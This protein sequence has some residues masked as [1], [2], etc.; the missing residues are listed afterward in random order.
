MSEIMVK[1]P[2][3]GESVTEATVS[4]WLVQPGSVVKKYEPLLEAMSDKV[5]TE[6]PASEDGIVQTLL[7]TEGDVVS[8]GSDI[9]TLET[10]SKK[11]EP[12]QTDSTPAVKPAET[13]TNNRL[14]FSPAVLKIAG[15][16][17]IDLNEVKGTGTGG[18]I[19]RKD[20]LS[21]QPSESIPQTVETVV[22]EKP[23]LDRPTTEINTDDIVTISPLRKA[24]AKNLVQSVTEIP[25]AWTMIEVDVTNLVKLRHN[26]KQAFFEQ[27]G[28]K[29]SFFPFFV[30][31]VNQALMNHPKLNSSWQDETIVYHDAINTSIAVATEE[32]LFVPVIKNSNYLSV[33]GIA[34][35]INRLVDK[36]KTNSLT[37]A[38]MADGTFTVN[39]TG[40]FG[41][42][43]SKGII[44]PPQ[45]A[46]L[47]VEAIRK[48]V[49]VMP[50]EAIAVR[51]VVNLCLTIDHRILDGLAAG[52]FLNEVKTNLE[53]IDSTTNIY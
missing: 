32:A 38:D 22:A 29:L 1:M 46:I 53:T 21:Y 18:R 4:Q 42:R 35:E 44:N 9:L 30:K 50:D 2:P 27:N 34:S 24:I 13:E 7:V 31:A 20:V 37:S 16:Q 41:S 51:D 43:E 52:R 39:N 12:T 28:F 36:V 33:A 48:E 25:Q 40:S 19:T 6:I 45:A 23:V 10:D 47:Q 8:I 5:T 3:L 11:T 49:K 14:R 15:E 26:L 17:G